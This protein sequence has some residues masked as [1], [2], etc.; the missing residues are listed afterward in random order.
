MKQHLKSYIGLIVSFI[1]LKKQKSPLAT[2]DQ[3]SKTNSSQANSPLCPPIPPLFYNFI[4]AI[5]AVKVRQS[6]VAA[7]LLV[8]TYRCLSVYR[9]GQNE[10]SGRNFFCVARYNSSWQRVNQ[11]FYTTSDVNY[12]VLFVFRPWTEFMSF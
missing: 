9:K 4:S 1:H 2:V 6:P 8:I 10:K 11:P 3:A 5:K 12:Q 7:N